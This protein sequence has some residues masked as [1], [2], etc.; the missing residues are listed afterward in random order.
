MPTKVRNI[1]SRLDFLAPKFEFTNFN[2]IT[3]S[4]AMNNFLK[5]FTFASLW[6]KSIVYLLKQNIQINKQLQVPK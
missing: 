2:I 4:I 3:S 6:V 5:G 1:I